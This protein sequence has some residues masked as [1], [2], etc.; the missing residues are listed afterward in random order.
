MQK[1]AP[2]TRRPEPV[3]L[4]VAP[5]M[6]SNHSMSRTRLQHQMQNLPLLLTQAR[7]IPN[8]VNGKAAGFVITDIVPG[9]LYQQ[10][11]L[12]NGD[13]LT[14]V[15]GQLITNPGQAMQLYQTLQQASTIDLELTRAGQVQQVHYD[16]R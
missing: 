2:L 12:Q 7:V 8:M 14:K 16:I 6:P 4:S 5:R 10:A 13:I 3:N 9:S 11:G 1:S 15:N